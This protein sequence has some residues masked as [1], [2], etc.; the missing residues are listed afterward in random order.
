[1]VGVLDVLAGFAKDN[2]ATRK[3]RLAERKELLAEKK[4]LLKQ[5]ALNKYA[6]DEAIYQK[7]LGTWLNTEKE[8]DMLKSSGTALNPKDLA[9]KI[10]TIEGRIPSNR[11]IEDEEMSQILSPYLANIKEYE[12]ENGNKKFDYTGNLKPVA[13]SFDKY[14]N[15]DKY[16]SAVDDMSKAVQGDW[17]RFVKGDESIAKEDKI[18]AT[19]QNDL[20][21]GSS[22]ANLDIR[23]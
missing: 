13:P 18:L 22:R 19:L 15:P 9:T 6:A 1:M 7:N 4:D 21:E 20:E 8:L 12:D 11:E 23:N 16:I 17:V 5:V 3:E 10:A 2:E 14:Y